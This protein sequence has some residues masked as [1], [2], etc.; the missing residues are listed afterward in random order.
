MADFTG[1][2]LVAEGGAG[3]WT[4]RVGS[5]APLQGPVGKIG[6]TAAAQGPPTPAG[7]RVVAAED[8]ERRPAPPAGMDAKLEANYPRRARLQGVEGSVSLRVRI[9]PDGRLG[10]MHVM[11]ETPEGW[12]FADACR[13]TLQEGGRWE[14]PLGRGGVAVATDV[15]YLC[16]FEVK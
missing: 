5:G 6:D 1:E 14:R 12:E 3:G 16:R 11:R 9:L 4:T 7:P 15:K 8:L 10:T 2:T 13:K